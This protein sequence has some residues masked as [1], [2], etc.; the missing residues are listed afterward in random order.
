MSI[1]VYGYIL[2][3]LLIIIFL[4]KP[5]YLIYLLIISL[6]LQVTSLINIG[7]YYSLQIY[8]F[9]TILVSVL[10]FIHLTIRG[11]KIKFKNKILKEISFYGIVFVFFAIVWSFIAPF[12]FAGY[13]V[14]PPELGVD[15]SAVYGPSPLEFSEYNIAFSIYILFYVLTL[16]FIITTNWDQN[17]LKILH[18]TFMISFLIILVTSISQ[19]LNVILKTP[20][21]TTYLYTITTREFRL[22]MAGSFPRVQATYQEPSMLAPFIVGVYSYYLYSTFKYKNVLH[23]TMTIVTLILILLSTS[24][25]AYISTMI[26][27]LLVLY[28]NLPLRIKNY[29]VYI[30]PSRIII[31]VIIIT[32]ALLIFMGVIFFT[33]GFDSFIFLINEV[34][35]N[36]LDTASYKNRTIAD[37]HA[38]K[39]FVDTY[40]LGVGLG[41]NRPSSLLPF[42]LSQLG[43]VGTWLF[44]VFIY[45]IMYFTCKSLKNTEYFQYFFL[46]PAVL[47]SQLIAYPDI[48]NPTL[49]QFIYICIIF[50]SIFSSRFQN[51]ESL[52]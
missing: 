42:L 17:D 51:N 18:R 27:T 40:G 41:S 36:K 1:T 8:R 4:I 9:I 35:I 38:L 12:I 34:L 43:F 14:F 26:L 24:T 45:K 33:A 20:D 22:S 19:I 44:L 25:T 32:A 49:W 3:P 29:T 13:P 6:T 16:L 15:F 46:L 30:N 2:I 31:N 5:K 10:F 47:V 52:S 11:F 37:L 23:L 7:D 28:F 50:S 21:I 39:L 48:T